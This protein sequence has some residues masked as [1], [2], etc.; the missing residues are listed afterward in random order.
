[1]ETKTGILDNTQKL[2]IARLLLKLA[3]EEDAKK[4]EEFIEILKRDIARLK[5]IV[6]NKPTAGTQKEPAKQIINLTTLNLSAQR[7]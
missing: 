3:E 1:M 4:N 2:A 5:T 6:A 7:R